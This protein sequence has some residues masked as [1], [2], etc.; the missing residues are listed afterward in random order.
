[1]LCV[2]VSEWNACIDLCVIHTS[3]EKRVCLKP[4][5]WDT[6]VIER[7]LLHTPFTLIQQCLKNTAA[8]LKAQLTNISDL[9]PDSVQEILK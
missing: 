2:G 7:L 4:E 9:F 8:P 3:L 1:M 5:E 6:P